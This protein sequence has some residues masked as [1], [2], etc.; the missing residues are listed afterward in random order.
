[1][2]SDLQIAKYRVKFYSLTHLTCHKNWHNLV[3]SLI[4]SFH[5]FIHLFIC[6]KQ[7]HSIAQ[8]RPKFMVS[9]LS[10]LLSPGITGILY[11]PSLIQYILEDFLLLAS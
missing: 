4:H 10:G 5:C 11:M 1:M 3:H 6:L 8:A 2:A 7:S 9:L